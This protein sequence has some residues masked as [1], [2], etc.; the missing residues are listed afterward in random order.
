MACS[1]WPSDSAEQ[2]A[3]L[4]RWSIDDR[5]AELQTAGLRI[6]GSQG[7]SFEAALGSEALFFSLFDFLEFTF[8]FQS[9][10]YP[11]FTAFLNSADLVG[12]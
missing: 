12:Q 6:D 3:G 2:L 8:Y 11:M 1:A 7:N 10:G 9:H 5:A 4:R